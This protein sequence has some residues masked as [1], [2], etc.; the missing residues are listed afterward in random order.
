MLDKSLLMPLSHIMIILNMEPAR[1]FLRVWNFC[2]H[3]LCCPRVCFLLKD[4]SWHVCCLNVNLQ[5]K[6]QKH[7]SDTSSSNR[8]HSDMFLKKSTSTTSISASAPRNS[9]H[10]DARWSCWIYFTKISMI[11]R[12]ASWPP[13]TTRL[14]NLRIFNDSNANDVQWRV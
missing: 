5:A 4:S 13:C 6:P 7:H 8:N 10:G 3:S 9:I 2:Q 11:F 1:G 14:I 12:C